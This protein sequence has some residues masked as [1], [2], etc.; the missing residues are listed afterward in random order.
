MDESRYMYDQLAVLA[1]IMLAMTA[2]TPIFKGRLSAVDVRWNA[3]GQ[4]V[5]DRTAVERGLDSSADGDGSDGQRL[6]IIPKSR[7]GSVSMIFSFF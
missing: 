6:G 5:D 4:S 3:I 1:P 7:Y 2:A